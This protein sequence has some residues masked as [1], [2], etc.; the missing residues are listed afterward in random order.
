MASRQLHFTAFI[1][2]AG[3]HESAWRV[4]PED[5]AQRAA[6]ALLRGD[7]AD[8]RGRR[9]ST[10]C[11]CADNM[12]I[13]EYRVEY[14]PQTLFDPVELLSA[15]AARHRADRADRDRLDD[16]QR[17]VGSRAAVRDARLPQRRPRRLEHRDDPLGADRRQLRRL[18]A[19]GARRALR[20]GGR[21]RRGRA[22][23]S[24]TAGRTT[25]SSARRRRASGRDAL[26]A[27]RAALRT[28]S[29]YQVAG[30]LP[31][32]RSPQGHPVLVQAGSS[33]CRRSTSPPAT[34]SSC[35]RASRRSTRR[36]RSAREL[37]A[38]ARAAGRAPDHVHVLPALVYTLGS[39]EAE[40]RERQERARGDAPAPSS[41][42]ATCS[43]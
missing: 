8:R 9:R 42:G 39:T 32:P 16:L 31:F 36:S 12:A 40:A 17:A 3:Y 23:A 41:A 14:M 20:A 27:P 7:R 29:T 22:P 6:P 1:Y 13:P 43:G 26:E 4:V 30:I 37:R 11:S 25:P 34:P 38:R 21:V 33:G 19:P 2:P 24:G 10:R 28:A 35:S 5:P 15:L 18:G